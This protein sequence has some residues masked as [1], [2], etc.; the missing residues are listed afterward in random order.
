MGL[1]KKKWLKGAWIET[2][3]VLNLPLSSIWPS[4]YKRERPLA[5]NALQRRNLF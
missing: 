2:L 5:V 4:E 1:L 3:W